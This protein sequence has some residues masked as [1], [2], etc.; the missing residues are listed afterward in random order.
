MGNNFPTWLAQ[1]M[2]SHHLNAS[3]LSYQLGVSH[4]AV[5]RW[6]RGERQPDDESVAKLARYFKVSTTE[7]YRHLGR[8]PERPRDPY[9]ETLEA[10]WELAPEWK[11]KD[12]VNQL[13]LAV[14]EYQ[15]EQAKH[16]ARQQAVEPTEKDTKT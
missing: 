8:I 9:Y 11:K 14:E 7:I 5:G 15:R 12:I 13:R 1:Q 2:E 3:G 16:K 10:L 6:L 4:V